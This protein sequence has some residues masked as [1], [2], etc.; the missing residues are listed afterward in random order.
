MA[1]CHQGR[2]GLWDTNVRPSRVHTGSKG[3]SEGR[4]S[5]FQGLE[6][7]VGPFPWGLNEVP[8]VLTYALA[9]ATWGVSGLDPTPSTSCSRRQS[10]GEWLRL[11][12]VAANAS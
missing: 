10:F 4:S 9:R 5:G 3:S 8:T 2:R 11:R 6:A 1:C 7:A 12:P